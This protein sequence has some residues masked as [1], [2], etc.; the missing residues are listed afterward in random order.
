MAAAR[1]RQRGSRERK[2]GGSTLSWLLLLEAGCRALA[3]RTPSLVPPAVVRTK[4][5]AVI[6][7]A[8]QR[9]LALPACCM[10]RTVYIARVAW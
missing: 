10:C 2:T 4:F 5:V 8:F 9:P 7:F 1:L 3:D 6:R